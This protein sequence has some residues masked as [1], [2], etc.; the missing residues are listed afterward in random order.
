MA[1]G[2]LIFFSSVVS[3]LLLISSTT[4]SFYILYS[5]SLEVPFGSILHLP[6]LSQVFLY[7]LNHIEYIYKSRFNIFVFSFHHL[8]HFWVCYYWLTFLLLVDHIFP[9]LCIPGNFFIG[10]PTLWILYLGAGFCLISSISV[11]FCS[12]VQL[13]Y[14]ESSLFFSKLSLKPE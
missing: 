7:L 4:F 6:F 14:L 10:C 2:S 12:G 13:S 3:Y 1:S 5:S 11:G 8:C 9:L